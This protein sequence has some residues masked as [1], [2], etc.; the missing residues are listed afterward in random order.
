MLPLISVA[1]S[2]LA[3]LVGVSGEAAGSATRPCGH[4]DVQRTYPTSGAR[5]DPWLIQNRLI[6]TIPP[7]R[8]AGHVE[9]DPMVAPTD[10]DD[11]AFAI[12]V[13]HGCNGEATTRLDVQIPTNYVEVRG[14]RRIAR[15]SLPRWSCPLALTASQACCARCR[16]WCAPRPA[17]W[18]DGRVFITQ[19]TT[20]WRIMRRIRSTTS[21]TL[22]SS[23][24]A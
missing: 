4:Y 11:F 5:W 6:G 18:S 19:T 17:P 10:G 16:D 2:C 24:W 8:T 20:R 13:G 7:L 23:S 9:F 12:N 14:M 3:L 1:L 22:P 15:V 21:P